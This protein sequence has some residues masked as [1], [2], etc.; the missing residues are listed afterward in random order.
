MTTPL[1]DPPEQDRAGTAPP[2]DPKRWA[3]L[4]V[5]LFAAFMDLLDVTIVNVAVPSIQKDIGA[6]YSAVTWI[7]AGYALSFAALLITGGR[8]GDIFGR[9]RVLLTGMAGFT[10]ASLLCGIAGDPG[11]L[12]AAR[13]LQGA[14]AALMIPQVLSIIHVAF[15]PEERGK[16]F[17]MFSGIGGLALIFG[18]ILGGILVEAELF[19]S[20]WRP[21]FL[22]NIPVGIATFV[23]ALWFVRESKDPAA[24]RLDVVGVV[25]ATAG[26]LML[27][28][29]LTQGRELGWPLWSFAMMAGSL[30]VLGGFVAYERRLIARGRSPLIPLEMFRARSFAGGFGVNLLYSVGYGTFFMMWTLYMQTGLGWSAMRAGLTGLPMFLGLLVAAGTTVQFLVPRFGRRV[31][32]AGGGLLMAGALALILVIG[33]YGVDVSPWHM[34]GPLFVFGLG[35]GAVL[36]PVIDFALNDVPQ[37]SAGSASGVLNTSGQLGTAV[38]IALVAVLFL[39]VLPHESGRGVDSV[40]ASV[41]HE[42]SVAGVTDRT[43]QEAVLRDW[44]TCTGDRLGEVDPSVVPASCRTAPAGT[45]QQADAVARVL[46]EHTPRAQAETFSRS[47]RSGM[48]YVIALFGLM[49]LVMLALPKAARAQGTPGG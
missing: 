13:I 21:I 4:S 14:A 8:L 22:F 47:F 42:L 9:R 37:D 7:T 17:G 48:G 5:V 24:P 19:G 15:P 16:V 23:A 40:E 18:P 45:P 20:P 2:P 46:A 11:T 28:Y 35:M 33:R 36:A 31:L 49:T 26:V 12:T 3:A 41:R 34:S 6:S 1:A 25:L 29:P 27:V 43:A 30:L 10:V 44:R 38:G 32:F 39:A